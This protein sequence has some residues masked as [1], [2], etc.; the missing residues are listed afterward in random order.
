LYYSL[1]S[2][3]RQEG[4]EMNLKFEDMEFMLD[5]VMFQFTEAIPKFFPQ[6]T[7]A[8][9]KEGGAGKKRHLKP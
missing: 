2:G 1:V 4:I 7:P 5:E 9:A 6:T 8:P 3:A